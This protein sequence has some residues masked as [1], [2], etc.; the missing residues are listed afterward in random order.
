M[1]F[2]LKNEMPSRSSK[3]PGYFL[4]FV[5][6]LKWQSALKMRLGA[7]GT[8]STK[9]TRHGIETKDDMTFTIVPFFLFLLLY[10]LNQCPRPCLLRMRAM[11]SLASQYRP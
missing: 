9:A 1:P 2:S 3:I 7:C 4:D 8:N 6:S 10:A 5:D 11:M